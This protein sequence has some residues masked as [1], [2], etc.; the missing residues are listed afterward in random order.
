MKKLTIIAALL[1]S[2]GSNAFSQNDIGSFFQLGLDNAEKMS[3]AYLN[4]YGEMLGVN[5]NTGWYTAASVHKI[6]GFDLTFTASYSKVPTAGK[7][8][9][10]NSIGLDP[11]EF[12][13]VDPAKNMSPTMAGSMSQSDLPIIHSNTTGSDITL[14]N[15][16]GKDFMITQMLQASVGLPFHTEVMA[17][18]MPKVSYGDLG[19]IGLWGIGIKH[20]IK[21]YIPVLKR[22]PILQLSVLGGYTKFDGGM[23]LIDVANI[24][25]DSRMDISSTAITTRLLIGAN[26]PVVAIYTGVGYGTSDSKFDISGIYNNTG[27]DPVDLMSLGFNTSGFDFNAGMRLRLGIVGIHFDYSVGEYPVMT[28]GIGINFR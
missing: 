13:L 4:P 24:L 12:S 15:G 28:G 27:T 22:L 3:Q 10:V 9:D 14:P 6:G 5:L 2:I 11:A 8:F 26:L 25:E 20:S 7:T 1:L 18:Y 19:N 16:S 21:E 23:K 17:R